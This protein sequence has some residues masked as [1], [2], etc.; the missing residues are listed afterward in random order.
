MASIPAA[1]CTPWGAVV[2]VFP[3]ARGPMR[4]QAGGVFARQRLAG[5]SIGLFALTLTNVVPGSAVQIE[6]AASGAVLS[7]QVAASSSVSVTLPAYVA[8][9]AGNSLRIKVR[10]GS[11]SPFYIPYETLATAFVGAGSI[12]V[13]QTPDE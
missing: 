13:S 9:S 8:G 1:G 10:K 6:V 12:F 3:D 11:A 7:N 2:G 4:P 5:D